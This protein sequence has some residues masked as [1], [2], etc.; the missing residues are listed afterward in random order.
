[1]STAGACAYLGKLLNRPVTAD[2]LVFLSSAQQAR[3]HAWLSANKIAFKDAAFDRRFRLQDLL[4]SPS[5]E[6]ARATPAPSRAVQI[7]NLTGQ[8]GVDIQRVAELFPDE[9]SEDLKSSN[10]LREIFTLK[11][12]SYAQTRSAPLDTL[13]GLFAAKEAALKCI[14]SVD[15][16]PL[17]QFEILPDSTGRP[18]LSGFRISIS[19]S[20]EYAVA[21][22][23]R[24]SETDN[25]TKSPGLR[26]PV[27]TTNLASDASKG[28]RIR[29]L[30][31]VNLVL[32]LLLAFFVLFKHT[33]SN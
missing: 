30:E 20:G 32:I 28:R 29:I 2:E 16:L 4:D 13:A 15:R 6:V 8:I 31:I 5:V 11:E 17:T 25:R 12:L 14:E 23:Q 27:P 24:I 7:D 22:A 19:H 33:L 18:S 9:V 3:F 21:V 10:E 26:E 1:M